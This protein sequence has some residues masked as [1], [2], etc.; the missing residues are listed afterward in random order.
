MKPLR[1]HGGKFRPRRVGIIA[2]RPLIEQALHPLTAQ[3]IQ[4]FLILDRGVVN[5][6]QEQTVGVRG[7]AAFEPLLVDHGGPPVGFP[8][9]FRVVGPDTQRVRSIARKP[10]DD[11]EQLQL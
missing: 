2:A 5:R 7:D 1:L 11:C 9:Q 8:V 6:R 4:A 10:A 3:G